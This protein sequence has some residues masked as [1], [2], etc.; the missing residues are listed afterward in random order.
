MILRS[1]EDW[2][3]RMENI[4]KFELAVLAGIDIHFINV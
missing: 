1:P 3:E 4:V 2:I